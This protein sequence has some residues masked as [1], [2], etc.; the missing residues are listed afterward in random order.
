[1]TVVFAKDLM[2]FEAII[3][4]V[5]GEDVASRD[6]LRDENELRVE[7]VHG[8]DRENRYETFIWAHPDA[9]DTVK[10]L[11][12][13]KMGYTAYFASGCFEAACR[14]FEMNCHKDL[15]EWSGIRD[16][17]AEGSSSLLQFRLGCRAK[18]AM[19]LTIMNNFS[20]M[21]KVAGSE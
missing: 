5:F 2:V 11:L 7:R 1:M 19:S 14:L 18:S 6:V 8:R 9:W 17:L 4:S 10:E 16:C 13:L 20:Q 21:C 3:D 12:E 15:S